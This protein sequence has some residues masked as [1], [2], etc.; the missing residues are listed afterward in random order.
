VRDESARDPVRIAAAVSLA[1]VA[2]LIEAARLDLGAGAVPALMGGTPEQF[3]ERYHYGSPAQLLPLGIPQLLNHGLPDSTVPARM[4]ADYA[5]RARRLGD[6]VEYSP[7]AGARHMEMIDPCGVAFR[8]M[9]DR[10]ARLFE[11]PLT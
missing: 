11:G 10:L 3:P 8:E 5:Q 6:D 1:G 4:S 9:M 7:V 2:D